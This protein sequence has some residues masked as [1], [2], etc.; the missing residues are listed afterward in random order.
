VKLGGGAARQ[1]VALLQ[2]KIKVSALQSFACQ[3]LFLVISQKKAPTQKR[4]G[5]NLDLSILYSASRAWL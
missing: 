5:A 3:P 4:V 2:R 1:R